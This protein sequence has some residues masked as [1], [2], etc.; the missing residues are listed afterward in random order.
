MR[1]LLGLGVLLVSV[2]P[3]A[4]AAS[5]ARTFAVPGRLAALA[6]DG[7]RVAYAVEPGSGCRSVWVWDLARGTRTQV[8]GRR[9]CEIPRTS[10]GGGL[11]EVALS[12]ATVAWIVR[13]GGNTEQA[14]TL[15]VHTPTLDEQVVSRARQAGEVGGAMSGQWLGYLVASSSGVFLDA[16]T[17]RVTGGVQSFGAA[18]VWRLS[19]QRTST[20]VVGTQGLFLRSASPGR[21][22]ALGPDGIARTFHGTTPATKPAGTPSV[23]AIAL[24]GA[25]LVS[26]YR[27]ATLDV[28]KADDLLQG[29]LGSFGAP[30]G[31]VTGMAAANGI[32]VFAIGRVLYAE[33]ETTG[34][35]AVLARS[36]RAWRF[37]ALDSSALVYAGSQTI[38][39][40]PFRAVRAAVS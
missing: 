30:P 34:K 9:T 29:P 33:S 22:A 23:R 1:R 38:H 16:W 3:P 15:F 10:T 2:S 28:R 21:L 20:Y 31:A 4:T 12:G 32:A 19:G 13:T 5:P 14:E 18:S 8:S 7:S 35:T 6:L 24:D 27:P 25:R 36:T 39:V 17:T 26:L 40:L 11:T 37:V